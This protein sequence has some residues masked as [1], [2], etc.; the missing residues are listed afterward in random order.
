MEP[1]KLAEVAIW[2]SDFKHIPLTITVE[3]D[4]YSDALCIE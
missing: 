3:Q 4:F 2:S 1:L